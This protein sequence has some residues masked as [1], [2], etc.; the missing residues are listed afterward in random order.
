MPVPVPS[1]K[2][3]LKELA[4]FEA[5]GNIED[6]LYRLT[7]IVADLV[8]ARRVSLMLLDACE[9]G[10]AQLKLAALY[11]EL[12]DD[13][14]RDEAEPDV[15]IA[16]HVLAKGDCL[17]A[18]DINRSPWKNDARRPGAGGSFMACPVAI[19]G[20]TAGVLNISEPRDRKAFTAADQELAELAAS[21]M[22]RAIQI[23]RLARLLDSRF[24]QMAMTLEGV[25]DASSVVALS[26]QDPERLSKMLAKA[27]YKEMRHCGF[28]PNQIIHAAGE[29]IS[30]LTGSLNRHK[31]RLARSG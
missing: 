17:R 27:F 1:R 7:C 3:K 11:G 9:R 24:A 12:P 29:I 14:W 18:A 21:L 10:G 25:Q 13:A 2:A 26:A 4:D 23:M 6:N 20:Q 19:A 5:G 15:G 8:G 22:G 31:R 28:T 16:K 30:E